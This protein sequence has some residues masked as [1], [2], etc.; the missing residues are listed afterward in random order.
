M[1][2]KKIKKK[3]KQKTG[4]IISWVVLVVL[5][6]ILFTM[7][8]VEV[9]Y[10][11]ASNNSNEAENVSIS[12][13][14]DNVFPYYLESSSDL[15]FDMIGNDIAILNDDSFTLINSNSAKQKIKEQHGYAN[16]IIKSNGEYSIIYDQGSYKFRLYN[17]KENIYEDKTNNKIFCANVSSSGTVGIVTTSDNAKAEII[18]YDKALN[19]MLSYEV[20][21]GFVTSIALDSGANR[22]AFAVTSSKNAQLITNV[23]VMKLGD[24]EP[25]ATF[26]YNDRIID[27]NFSSK[28]LYI[29][30][31][32]FVSL[33]KNMKDEIK[34][35]EDE[36]EL[37]AY[38]F[39][40]NGSLNLAVSNYKGASVDD[41]VCVNTNGKIISRFS[42]EDRIKDLY[43]DK[44][45]IAVLTNDYVI[46]YN[47]RNGKE[48]NRYLVDDS[49]TSI[50]ENSS[51]IYLKHQSLVERIKR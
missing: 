30:G 45:E 43:S 18:V 26:T 34:I 13:K 2:D 10:E 20:H 25:F 17:S 51:D 1:A 16:P 9:Y 29:V 11:N 14:E 35:F 12:Q 31:S 38:S 44:Y 15:S 7:K 37:K 40:K 8:M 6:I 50:L 23:Y 33:I 49:Y 3:H 46:I 36:I 4:Y 48:K 22:I 39:N 21:N 42:C 32:T 28:N 47:L 19:K 41:V 24:K 27:L 5:L